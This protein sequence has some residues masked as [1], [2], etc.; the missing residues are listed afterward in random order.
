MHRQKPRESSPMSKSV[1][2]GADLSFITN[3]SDGLKHETIAWTRSNLV[4][5]TQNP[6]RETERQQ[7]K[8]SHSPDTSHCPVG[9][10]DSDDTDSMCPW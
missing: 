6:K 7:S 9:S 5:K 10:T 2:Y 8:C 1:F 3:A 4:F